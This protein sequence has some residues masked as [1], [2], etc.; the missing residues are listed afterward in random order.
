MGRSATFYCRTCKKSYYLGYGS[1]GTWLDSVTSVD[2]FDQH[3]S[4]PDQLGHLKKNSNMRQC[5]VAHAGH[6]YETYSSDYTHVRGG[7]LYGEFGP[8]GADVPL[9]EDYGQWT[10]EDLDDR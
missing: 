6:K 1:Y 7:V 9:I 10:H 8:M 2:E 5:L 4:G 3:A